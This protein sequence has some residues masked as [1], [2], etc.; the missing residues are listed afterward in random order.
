MIFI[1]LIALI[2]ES[3]GNCFAVPQTTERFGMQTHYYRL[4]MWPVMCVTK[5]VMVQQMFEWFG[6]YPEK[7]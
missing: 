6:V 2:S 3:N 4:P 7:Q 1:I 5:N